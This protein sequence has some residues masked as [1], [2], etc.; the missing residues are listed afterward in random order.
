MPRL[1]AS[2][3]SPSAQEQISACL[4]RPNSATASAFDMRKQGRADLQCSYGHTA[5]I[6]TL[7]ETLIQLSG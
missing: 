1:A 4:H 5:D 7:L 3:G 2:A 6:A